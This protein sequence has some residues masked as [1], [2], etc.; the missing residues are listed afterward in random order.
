MGTTAEFVMIIALSFV[1][2]GACFLVYLRLIETTQLLGRHGDNG[3][4]DVND[5]RR[6]LLY[7]PQAQRAS[8]LS[9]S[10]GSNSLLAEATAEFV[11]NDDDTD[12]APIKLLTLTGVKLGLISVDHNLQ[13]IVL[14]WEKPQ[15][16]SWTTRILQALSLTSTHKETQMQ[17]N[18]SDRLS[19][20]A[21][22]YDPRRDTYLGNTDSQRSGFGDNDC[23]RAFDKRYKFH[24]ADILFIQPGKKTRNFENLIFARG[25]P[26]Y[27]CFSIICQAFTA[28]IITDTQ[29]TRDDLLRS[30][31]ELLD[32]I[33]VSQ[34]SEKVANSKS[35]KDAYDII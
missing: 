24:A 11:D 19:S 35:A 1:T 28:D 9:S 21:T 10:R 6:P 13:Q 5:E 22:M 32:R 33:K 26:D 27:V 15:I 20:P 18:Y 2:T 23:P 4:D 14:S 25:V 16:Q 3:E 7:R 8:S 34:M 31:T 12:S 17:S 29:S 30:V